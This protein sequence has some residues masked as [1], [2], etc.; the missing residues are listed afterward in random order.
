MA[1]AP[2]GGATN[3]PGP[4][5]EAAVGWPDPGSVLGGR[6]RLDLLLRRG[7]V[8]AVFRGVD[9]ALGRPVAVKVLHPAL[10]SESRAVARFRREARVA[11]GIIHPFVV[12]VF[13]VGCEGDLHYMVM[14]YVDGPTLRDELRETGPFGQDRALEVTAAVCGALAAAH[15]RGLIHRDV[16]PAN[17]LL[18][19]EGRVKMT[20]FGIAL[21]ARGAASGNVAVGTAAY[22]SPE[23]A[24]GEP[25]GPASDLYSAGCVLYEMLTGRPP[26]AGPTPQAIAQKHVEEEPVPPS[27]LRPDVAPDVEG[28]VLRAL[29]KDP[30][31]RYR[32]ASEMGEAVRLV[33]RS[34]P[35][36]RAVAASD[37]PTLPLAPVEPIGEPVAATPAGRGV[38]RDLIRLVV[39]TAAGFVGAVLVRLFWGG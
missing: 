17:I 23:Q 31:R 19:R 8:A 39:L 37:E 1:P 6:Y 34:L 18:S 9:L 7:D 16:K 4:G 36:P 20:D 21:A 15:A 22:L 12:A 5:P 3:Q 25:V 38:G 26:F 2:A 33:L 30:A 28:A 10:A 14:E 32:D 27:R 13:D 35:S 24:R 29:A 11:A